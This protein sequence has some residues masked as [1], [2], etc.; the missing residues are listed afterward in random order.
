[1]LA[2]LSLA[3]LV[4]ALDLSSKHL[5]MSRMA[6]GETITILP[7]LLDFT[8]VRN[9]GAAYGMLAGG[10]WF[11]AAIALILVALALFLAP[12]LQRPWERA[13]L[14]LLIGGALGNMLDRVR[15]GLVT[16]FVQIEP[17][18]IFQVFN[19]ADL[20]ISAAVVVVASAWLLQRR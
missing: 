14:G 6:P 12:R 4:L 1:M 5:I 15:W 8:Y 3:A 10:R 20:A 9:P 2:T 13:A 16:D 18:P 17:L 7:R 19:L 11:L